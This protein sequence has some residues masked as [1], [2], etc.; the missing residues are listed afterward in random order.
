MIRTTV[1]DAFPDEFTGTG[2]SRTIALRYDR[3]DPT[4]PYKQSNYMPVGTFVMLL[5]FSAA[6]ISFGGWMLYKLR[7]TDASQRNHAEPSDLVPS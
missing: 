3:G 6:T 7:S 5:I 4:Q 1:T 2:R